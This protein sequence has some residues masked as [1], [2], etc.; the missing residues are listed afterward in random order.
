MCLFFSLPD[1]KALIKYLVED[2]QFDEARVD[3]ALKRLE[4]SRKQTSQTRMDSF[5]KP[6]NTSA[7]KGFKRKT[8]KQKGKGVKRRK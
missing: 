3:S 1:K 5:F 4:K 6:I 2:K 7:T 8:T